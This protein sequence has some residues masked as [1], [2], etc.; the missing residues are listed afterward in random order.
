V[1]NDWPWALTPLTARVTAGFLALTGASLVA[2]ANDRRWSAGRAM[3]E[4]LIMGTALILAAVPRAWDNFD[5]AE[6]ARWFYVGGLT[7]GLAALLWLYV[8]MERRQRSHTLLQPTAESSG[9]A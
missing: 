5:P 3:L 6:P 1:L 8:S 2:I 9:M 4:S 7:A